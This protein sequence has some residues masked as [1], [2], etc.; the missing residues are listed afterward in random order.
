MTVHLSNRSPLSPWRCL[1]VVCPPCKKDDWGA[2][3]L[4]VDWLVRLLVR[5]FVRPFVRPSVRLFVIVCLFVLSVVHAFVIRSFV[6]L[7][8]ETRVVPSTATPAT[9]PTIIAENTGILKCKK[10]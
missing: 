3:H 1:R 7:A 4:F 2:Q 6:H 5:L 8:R 10:N 9:V